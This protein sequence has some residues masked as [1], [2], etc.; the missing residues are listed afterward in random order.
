MATIFYNA[1]VFSYVRSWRQKVTD[2]SVVVYKCKYDVAVYFGNVFCMLFQ[3]SKGAEQF[4]L[5]CVIEDSL[6]KL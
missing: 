3:D 5:V 2:F 4:S 1:G 6:S